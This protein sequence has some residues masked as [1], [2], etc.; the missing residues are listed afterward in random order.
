MYNSISDSDAAIERAQRSL[1]VI[2]ARSA[3]LAALFNG[4]RPD[5]DSCHF[6]LENLARTAVEEC[7]TARQN[8]HDAVEAHHQRDSARE[9]IEHLHDDCIDDVNQACAV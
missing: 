8:L 5:V 7:R 2:E 4:K 3:A 9:I 1:D 6:M